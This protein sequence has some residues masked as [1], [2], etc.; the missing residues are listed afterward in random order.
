MLQ[1]YV[2]RQLAGTHWAQAKALVN[3]TVFMFKRTY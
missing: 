2:K 1:A 3:V